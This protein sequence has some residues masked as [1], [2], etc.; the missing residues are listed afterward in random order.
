MLVKVPLPP[1]P[2]SQKFNVIP[3]PS[4]TSRQPPTS[5]STSTIPEYLDTMLNSCFFGTKIRLVLS[6]PPQR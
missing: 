6:R 1:F 3:S 5:S 4:R 2:I